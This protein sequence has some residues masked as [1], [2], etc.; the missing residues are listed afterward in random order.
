MTDTDRPALRDVAPVPPTLR[1]RWGVEVSETAIYQTPAAEWWGVYRHCLLEPSGAEIVTLVKCAMGDVVFI[2]RASK[3]S[4]E[5]LRDLIISKGAPKVA[6][7]VRQARN[8]E[9]TTR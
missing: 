6:A 9:R 1:A 8:P 5:F 4:A 2:P 7:T 3:A